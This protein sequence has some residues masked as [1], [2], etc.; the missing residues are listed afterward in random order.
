VQFLV[1]LQTTKI[2][3]DKNH[4]AFWASF[5]IRFLKI[6]FERP[7]FFVWGSQKWRRMPELLGEMFET[8]RTQRW[9]LLDIK[10]QPLNLFEGFLLRHTNLGIKWH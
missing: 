5:I 9:T 4:I 3:S 10:A 2:Q 7:H 1:C 8:H 6:V